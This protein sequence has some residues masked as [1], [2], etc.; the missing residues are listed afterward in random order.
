MQGPVRLAS[1]AVAM[2]AEIMAS[3]RIGFIGAGQMAEAIARGLDKA[4]VVP[5]DKMCASDVNVS[6]MKVFESLGTSV[7][8]SNK[9]VPIRRPALLIPGLLYPSCVCACTRAWL[10]DETLHLVSVSVTV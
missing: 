5:A 7:C 1:V 2:A 9:Q 6:R 4:G 10:Y 3:T 8:T